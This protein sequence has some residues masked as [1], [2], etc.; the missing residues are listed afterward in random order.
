L[1]APVAVG[2]QTTSTSHEAPW[3]SRELEQCSS[4]TEKIPEAEMLLN[5]IFFFLE[6]LV[7]C[8]VCGA[9]VVPTSTSP[10]S[11]VPELSVSLGADATDGE[12]SGCPNPDCAIAWRANAAIR[13]SIEKLMAAI[14][15]VNDLKRIDSVLRGQ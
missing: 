6:G 14:E 5:L 3:A 1:P 13:N 4:D 9:L 12:S 11:R 15:R 7:D 8:S 10:K 2:A